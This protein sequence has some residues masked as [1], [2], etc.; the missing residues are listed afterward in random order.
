MEDET[1]PHGRP[2]RGKGRFWPKSECG[3]GEKTQGKGFIA[4]YPGKPKK[5]S[6]LVCEGEQKE[7]RRGRNSRGRRS[8]TRERAGKWTREC[9]IYLVEEAKD[10]QK[11]RESERDGV[12]RLRART[13]RGDDEVRLR[14]E[15]E[16]VPRRE[17]GGSPHVTCDYHHVFQE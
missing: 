15:A 16:V 8:K 5:L 7:G 6:R 1:E 11:V 14:N 4:R 2:R 9:E 3:M 10:R 17:S 12:E 13:R